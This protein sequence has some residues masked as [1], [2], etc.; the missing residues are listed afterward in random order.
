MANEEARF[1]TLLARCTAFGKD[2]LRSIRDHAML[3]E[4]LASLERIDGMI[5]ASDVE[6]ALFDAVKNKTSRQ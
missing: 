1:E 6:H 2:Q 3:P 5:Y 4:V